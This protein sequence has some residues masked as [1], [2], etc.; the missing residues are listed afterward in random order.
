MRIPFKSTL[1]LSLMILCAFTMGCEGCDVE[2]VNK[3]ILPGTVTGQVCDPGQGVGI[4]GATVRVITT[5]LQGGEKIYETTTDAEGNFLLESIPVGTHT[6]YIRRGSF[7]HEV[8]VE[9]FED[10][11]TAFEGE[12][13]APISVAMAVYGGHDSVEEVLTRLGDASHAL[14][15]T[16]HRFSDRDENTPSWLVEEFGDPN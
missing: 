4:Y 16:H 14:V 5:T 10:E 11:N 13:V 6:V 2:P 8:E 9:V 1:A 12:C 7:R 3:V 15:D